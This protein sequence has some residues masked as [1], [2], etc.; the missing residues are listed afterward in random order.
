MY[1]SMIAHLCCTARRSTHCR[2]TI[3]HCSTPISGV[4]IV[5][6]AGDLS[7]DSSATM[8]SSPTVLPSRGSGLQLPQPDDSRDGGIHIALTRKNVALAV[9]SHAQQFNVQQALA[10]AWGA[11]LVSLA[12]PTGSRRWWCGWSGWGPRCRA[13]GTACRASACPTHQL[14]NCQMPPRTDPSSSPALTRTGLS[15]S[16]S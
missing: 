2:G 3:N 13:A 6:S 11:R 16:A 15:K 9:G 7:K 4:A 1:W 14:E 5:G 12:A 10:G 8:I